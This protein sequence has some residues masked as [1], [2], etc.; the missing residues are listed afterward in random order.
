MTQAVI[1]SDA[2]VGAVDAQGVKRVLAFLSTTCPA[3]E[4]L[5]ILGDLFDFWFG[6]KQARLEPYSTV[7]AAI[8]SLARTGTQVAFFH[9]NRDFYVD[10]KLAQAHGFRLV[11]DYAVETIC[12]RRVLLCHGDML[13]TNDA[14]YHRV[15]AIL[16]HPLTR[17]V[18][19]RLPSTVA[20][21]LARAFRRHSAMT[22]SSKS[23][24]VLGIDEGTLG[25]YFAKGADI[26]VC[27]HT[28]KEQLL[29]MDTPEGRRDL[30]TLG[31]FGL[32][33][34]YLECDAGN[35]IF[36]SAPPQT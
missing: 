12:G 2:H 17:A 23:Q 15:R 13:C 26:I 31:D 6:P 18:L 28:H 19:T 10:A 34:S 16:R 33:G 14:S 11:P 4:R 22:V 21:R 32:T 36:R 3:A 25:R 27:G 7:L 1:F 30:Y 20:L 29:S 35:F 8:D 24:W 9:G 5:Y